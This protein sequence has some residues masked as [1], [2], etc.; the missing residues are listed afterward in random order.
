MLIVIFKMKKNKIFI[1]KIKKKIACLSSW[2]IE[3]LLGKI[4]IFVN[5]Y[6]FRN[7]AK[8]K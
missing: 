8:S 3:K 5:F 6:R 4:D 2:Q 7:G 1:D